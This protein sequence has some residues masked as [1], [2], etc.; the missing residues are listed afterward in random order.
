M[1]I[2]D[3]FILIAAIEKLDYK[4]NE[5]EKEFLQ[6][7]EMCR[8]GLSSKQAK[9]LTSIYDKASGGGIFQKREYIKRKI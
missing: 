7:I 2:Q 6:N 8:Y 5:W 1:T 9:V 4:A 3:A